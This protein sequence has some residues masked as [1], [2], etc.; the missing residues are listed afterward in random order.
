MNLLVVFVQMRNLD[1]NFRGAGSFGGIGGKAAGS[2]KTMIA[3]IKLTADD[4][5]A[6]LA[7]HFTKEGRHAML[8]KRCGRGLPK[9]KTAT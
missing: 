4:D 6:V 2:Q 3:S 1:Q 8:H 9:T 7:A 5:G